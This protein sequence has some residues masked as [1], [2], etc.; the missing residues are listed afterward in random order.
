M[1]NDEKKAI[2]Y[3]PLIDVIILDDL[4]P[5]C[6]W[7]LFAR[8][9]FIM[10]HNINFLMKSSISLDSAWKKKHYVIGYNPR[11]LT[12][13]LI[14]QLGQMLNLYYSCCSNAES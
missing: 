11:S 5:D 9:R 3:W 13:Y 1:N 6:H 10:N 14:H 8:N 2:C 4:W 7:P 12:Y